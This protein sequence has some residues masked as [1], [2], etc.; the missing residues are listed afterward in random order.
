MSS[1]SHCSGTQRHQAAGLGGLPWSSLSFVLCVLV[2]VCLW[3][4]PLGL[5]SQPQHA[6]AIVCFTVIAWI[7]QAME[8]A[9]AGL[10]GCFLFWALG[11]VRFNVA[12]SGFANDTP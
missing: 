9:I 11:V 8:F 10:V 3:F 5:E 6:L 7:T 4:A 12:F 1:N 2:P